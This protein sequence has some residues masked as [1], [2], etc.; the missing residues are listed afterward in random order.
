MP[1]L[2]R[3]DGERYVLVEG[4]HRLE[5]CKQPRRGNILA[6]SCRREDISFLCRQCFW[7]VRSVPAGRVAKRPCFPAPAAAF[8]NDIEPALPPRASIRQIGPA[9]R[10]F[11]VLSW[12][13]KPGT[14]GIALAV[15]F[16]LLLAPVLNAFVALAF[17]MLWLP[18]AQK[19]APVTPRARRIALALGSLF[20]ANVFLVFKAVEAI[21]VPIAILT[22][23]VYPLLTGISAAAVGLEPLSWKGAVAALIAFVGLGVMLGAHPTGLALAEPLLRWLRRPAACCSFAD[24][25]PAARRDPL[26]ITLYSMVSSTVLFVP[27]CSSSSTRQPPATVLGWVAVIASRHLGRR[28]PG[29]FAPDW[30]HRP[31]SHRAL[32]E[33]EPLLRPLAAP[34]SWTR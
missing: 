2:V 18:F 25:R 32:H 15:G 29:V 16:V 26:A 8:S 19:S 3:K 27:A 10:G 21:E 20:A 9:V 11:G 4:L 5:A 22:Y 28:H 13:M 24:A 23:F 33:S 14:F 7:I 17:L 1:I 34:L 6:T 30:A 31:V 12:F